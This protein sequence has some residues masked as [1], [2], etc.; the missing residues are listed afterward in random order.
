MK[1]TY[2]ELR[3]QNSVFSGV[4][5]YSGMSSALNLNGGSERVS[6][7]LVSGNYFEVLGV[8]PYIGRLI[9]QEDDKVPGA[10]RTVVLSYG[11]WVR[12]FG[13][14]PTIVGKAI[15]LNTVP[16]T[17][18]G[19]SPPRFDGLDIGHPV[20]VRV[21]VMMQA[22]MWGQQ[23]SYL[24]SRGDWWLDVVARLKPD[25]T[26][27]QAEAAV[28]PPL[29]AYIQQTEMPANPTEYQGRLLAS[30]RVI[31]NPMARGAQSLGRQFGR[32]LYVLMAVVGA[33]LL[34]A[35]VNVANL[36]LARSAAREREIA[37][38]LALGSGRRRLI[39]QML[40][41]S[42]V[43]ASYRMVRGTPPK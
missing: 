39:R 3:D 22:E 2:R 31:F 20:D 21:P 40:T 36:L 24:E 14:D 5:C 15:H 7:E 32:S 29:M 4:L 33:V 25:V 6:G 18:M 12:R 9:T 17:I 8:K 26:R 30:Q 13:A 11:F 16:M 34:I 37:I 27:A 43:L 28:L 1:T 42:V 10:A 38:R 19:V 41:E 23:E 35:C